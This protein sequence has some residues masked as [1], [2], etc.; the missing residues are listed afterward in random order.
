LAVAWLGGG[1]WAISDEDGKRTADSAVVE[2]EKQMGE[3]KLERLLLGLEQNLI[4][5]G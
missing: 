4:I 2:P 1:A 3:N 5:I